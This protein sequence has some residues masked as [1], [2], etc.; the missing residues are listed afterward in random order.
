MSTQTA[1]SRTTTSSRPSNPLYNTTYQ[2]RIDE[3]LTSNH[4]IFF[5]YHAREN[6]RYAGTQIAPLDIDPGG[7]PQDFITHYARVGWDLDGFA[8][9]GQHAER[10]VQPHE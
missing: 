5:S 9:D 8:D 3:N 10:R 4:K 7:W 2:I 6:T 1:R